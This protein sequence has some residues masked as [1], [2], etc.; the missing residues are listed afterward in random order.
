ML[1]LTAAGD[2][3]ADIA[4]IDLFL[5]RCPINDPAYAE[6]R[7]DF[8]ILR[9]GIA[10]EAV[11]CAEPVSALP[12]WQYSEELILIQGL[13]VLYYMDRGRSN[14]LPWTNGTIYDWMKTRVRGFNLRDSNFSYCCDLIDG[15]YYVGIALQ[16]ESNRDFDRRWRGISANIGLYA[17]EVRHRDGYGHDSG[18]GIPFGCDA[19]FNLSSLSSYAIQWWLNASWLSGHLYVGFACADPST[20]ATIA[21]WHLSSANYATARFS[22]NP[23]PLLS[24]PAQPGGGCRDPGPPSVPT[25]VQASVSGDLLTVSWLPPA[26]GGTPTGYRVDFYY[27]GFAVYTITVGPSTQVSLVIPAGVFGTFSATVSGFSA[28]L[29]GPLSAAAVFTIGACRVPAA[30]AGVTT[31]LVNS[32]GTATWLPVPS[33]TSYIV[34]AGSFSGGVDLFNANVGATTTVSASG[35]PPGFRAFVRVI[36]VNACGNS[37]PSSIVILQ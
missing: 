8:R 33:A 11:Y 34:Q 35:L 37:S 5:E 19:E 24:M 2:A 36:A 25:S 15:D 12:I 10:V 20:A 6:I 17:H 13:R 1:T 14:H 3:R 31:S 23:P 28:A 9:N 21:E 18:C 29:A 26:S 32:V 27:G 16:D 7:Q 30:P 4:N 22:T